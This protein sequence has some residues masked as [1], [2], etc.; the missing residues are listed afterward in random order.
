[1]TREL[2]VARLERIRKDCDFY[3]DGNEDEIDKNEWLQDKKACTFGINAL[4]LP[5]KLIEILADRCNK[6]SSKYEW[7]ICKSLIDTVKKEFG[8]RIR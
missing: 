6:T 8:E 7:D 4:Q 3:I 1:M 5:D 2:A